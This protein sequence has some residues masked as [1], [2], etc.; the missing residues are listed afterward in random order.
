MAKE[1]WVE[2]HHLDLLVGGL[3]SLYLTRQEG[4]NSQQPSLCMVQRQGW[5]PDLKMSAMTA[6]LGIIA[7]TLQI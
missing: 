5:G 3:K 6:W 2:G 4:S 1:L 7:F